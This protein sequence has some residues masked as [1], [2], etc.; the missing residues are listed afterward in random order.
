MD[1][2]ESKSKLCWV[3]LKVDEIIAIQHMSEGR[4][5]L[6]ISVYPC[7]YLKLVLTDYAN[8]GWYHE[9]EVTFVKAV[10]SAADKN[11]STGMSQFFSMRSYS[12][13]LVEVNMIILNA[14]I[15]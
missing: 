6:C 15:K 8:K 5:E 4:V 3:F 9:R 13:I 11:T 1:S 10:S 14:L 12:V 7:I 2:C